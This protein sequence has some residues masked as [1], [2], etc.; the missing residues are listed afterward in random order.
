MLFKLSNMNSNLALTRP[1]ILNLIKEGIFFILQNIDDLFKNAYTKLR[2]LNDIFSKE[3][4]LINKGHLLLTVIVSRHWISP[5]CGVV[6]GF[7]TH[8]IYS[9]VN[10]PYYKWLEMLTVICIFWRK[11]KMLWYILSLMCRMQYKIHSIPKNNA[12]GNR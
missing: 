12:I 4:L 9:W 3:L 6:K 1:W 8:A 7:G 5:S 2:I 10:T 11:L